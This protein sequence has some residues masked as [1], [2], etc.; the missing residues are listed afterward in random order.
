MTLAPE[1]LDIRALA[2]EQSLAQVLQRLNR[3][4]PGQSLDVVTAHEPTPLLRAVLAEFPL[5]FDFSP[6]QPGPG[7][8]RYH[9][10]RRDTRPQRSVTDYLAWD[11]DRLDALLE[12]SLDHARRQDW[13]GNLALAEDFSHGLQRH[14]LIEEEILFPAFEAA[15]GMHEG[16]PTLVMRH[17]HVDIKACLGQILEGAR[18]RNLD[19]MEQSRANLLGVLVSHNMKEESILYPTT[20]RFHHDAAL[21]Q[22]VLK[23]MLG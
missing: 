13:A 9:I 20:D 10:Y 1:T 17:E 8:W 18:A 3:L 6:L 21:E 5:A 23:L 16:G 14:I 11:H 2:A 7:Q 4:K 15:T 22:L 19:A 12:S